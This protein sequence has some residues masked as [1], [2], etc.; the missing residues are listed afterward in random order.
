MKTN[1]PPRH[2][3]SKRANL[4]FLVLALAILLL[5]AYVLLPPRLSSSE[6]NGNSSAGNQNI[7]VT[8][9]SSADLYRLS[10][11][12]AD[13]KELTFQYSTTSGW[14]LDDDPSFPL[15][16]NTLTSMAAR[17][18]KIVASRVL[19]PISEKDLVTYGL[20]KPALTV[21]ASYSHRTATYYF[22]SVSG[23]GGSCYLAVE[24]ES[25]SVYVVDQTYYTI[26]TFDYKSL[27]DQVMLPR[28][29]AD[30]ILS[31]SVT[32]PGSSSEVT[33]TEPSYL[34][35]L[36]KLTLGNFVEYR[37]SEESLKEYGLTEEESTV[38]TV[39]YFEDKTIDIESGSSGTRNSVQVQY[40]Y[41]LRVGGSPEN[42]SNMRYAIYGDSGIVYLIGNHTYQSLLQ[43]ASEALLGP[44]QSTE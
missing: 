41:T 14:Q 18:S 8:N 16:Q 35:A 12:N 22:G 7:S 23:F 28:L 6:G 13:G 27:L 19:T 42:Q 29:T 31:Y 17:I 20:S 3:S 9:D 5:I 15:S 24:G 4:L 33:V 32:S 1:P 40:S 44:S 38:I 21:T 36:T 37:P 34:T 11:C 26:F 10:Y 25:N 43:G 30:H 39:H 2:F